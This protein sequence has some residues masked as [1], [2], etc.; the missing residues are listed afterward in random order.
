MARY[1]RQLLDRVILLLLFCLAIGANTVYGAELDPV[2]VSIHENRLF[3]NSLLRP[4]QRF[5]DSLQ[6]GISKEVIF[7]VDLFR[8]WKIWPDEF[9]SG[10][11]IKRTLRANPIKREYVATSQVGNVITEKRFRDIDSM[12]SWVFGLNNILLS[13]NISDYEEG[14]YYVKIT[15]ESRQ[16]NVPPAIGFFLFF[17]PQKE[18]SVYRNSLPFNIKNQ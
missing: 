10:L 6:Q 3:A 2:T 1:T 9:V 8:V 18:F 13:N 16:Q 11:K 5:L 15:A 14:V 17:I 4:E 7:Y 12:S